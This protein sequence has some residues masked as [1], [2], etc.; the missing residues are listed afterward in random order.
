[1]ETELLKSRSQLPIAT[2]EASQEG[3]ERINVI[4]SIERESVQQKRNEEDKRETSQSI[5]LRSRICSQFF[6]IPFLVKLEV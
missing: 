3:G 4:E 2:F 1:M 5:A 6:V